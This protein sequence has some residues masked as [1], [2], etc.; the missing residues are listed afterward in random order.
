MPTAAIFYRIILGREGVGPLGFL[1]SRTI[2]KEVGLPG[3]SVVKARV[4][5]HEYRDSM[6]LMFLSAQMEKLPGVLKAAVIMGTGANKD[7]LSAMDLAAPEAAEAGPSDLLAA[8]RAIDAHSASSALARLEEMLARQAAGPEAGEVFYHSLESAAAALPGANLSVISVPGLHAAREARKSLDL[9]LHVF[10]FSDNVPL[11]EE[12]ALKRTARDRDLLVMG[13]DCGTALIGGLALG[14]ANAV[15]RGRIGIVGASGTGIQEVSVLLH[16]AGLGISHALGTGGRDLSPEVGAITTLQGVELLER[17]PETDVLVI[18]SKKPPEEVSRLLQARLKR[19]PKPVVAC[20]LGQAGEETDPPF[21]R[22]STL[23]KAA[24]EAARISGCESGE[25]GEDPALLSRRAGWESR[26]LLPG[27]RLVRG[28]FSGGSLCQEAVSL[29]EDML[30]PVESN[31][32]PA[33]GRGLPD[34][35][36]SRGHTAIDLGD[37][38]FTAGRPHPM[39]DPAV[40]RERLL[41]EAD[42]PSVAVIVLDVVLGYGSHPDMAGA[43]LPAIREARSRAAARG[44]YLPFVA[45]VAGTEEDPQKA[46]DQ[47]NRLRSAGVVTAPTN[48]DAAWIAG[49]IAL[50]ERKEESHGKT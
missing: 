43:L 27:Q 11:E 7:L 49:L 44:R 1:P 24:R 47:E 20:F 29:W 40:R 2:V 17:D 10:L 16:R 6:V 38:F 18:L 13:P 39:I 12:A 19:C 21:R 4:L 3:S 45:H 46:G 33:P 5:R 26:K 31:P 35:G 22:V 34:P 41:R 8:V 9:G 48:A 30:G 42:D 32:H 37:D 14:F 15:R 28:L 50:G 25:F 23:A 36:F